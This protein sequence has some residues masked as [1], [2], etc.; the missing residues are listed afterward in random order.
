MRGWCSRRLAGADPVATEMCRLKAG[1]RCSPSQCLRHLSAARRPVVDTKP[2]SLRVIGVNRHPALC[3]SEA[4]GLASS[5]RCSAMVL[6]LN[7]S[8]G[9]SAG[10][11]VGQ[12]PC[13]ASCTLPS[14]RLRAI[15]AVEARTTCRS[16]AHHPACS[17]IPNPSIL[18]A[19]LALPFDCGVQS[20]QPPGPNFGVTRNSSTGYRAGTLLSHIT[21]S[22][23]SVWLQIALAALATFFASKV[24]RPHT[25]VGHDR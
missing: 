12:T 8:P 21:S 18:S 25:A 20:S 7:P 14:D 15:P 2:L 4:K 16:P 24:S 6:A 11:L 23:S 3:S 17:L 22:A 9:S 5:A 19:Q 1:N 10:S 13:E